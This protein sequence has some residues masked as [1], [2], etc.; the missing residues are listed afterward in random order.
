MGKFNISTVKSGEIADVAKIAHADL[1]I[2]QEGTEEVV[3]SPQGSAIDQLLNAPIDAETAQAVQ[4]GTIAGIEAEQALTEQREREAVPDIISRRDDKGRVD[5]YDYKGLE[6]EKAVDSAN[7]GVS[8]DGGLSARARNMSALITGKELGLGGLTAAAQNPIKQT[9]DS[10]KVLNTD[11]VLDKGFLQMSSVITENAI[12]NLAYGEGLEGAVPDF[13]TGVQEDLVKPKGKNLQPIP[14]A[15]GN[16]NIG[17]EINRE[18]QRYKNAQEGIPTDQYTDI[19]DEQATLLGD[20][21][22][23]LYYEANKND[24]GKEFMKR[25]KT[26][27]GQTAF[28]L[29][30]HGADRLK[31]GERKRKE[32]FP[33]Q[34]VRPTKTPTPGG[35]LVGEGRVYTKRVSSKVR[36]PI[37]G[38]EVLNAAMR[39][40]NKIPN[41]VDK[42]RL[43]ILFATAIPVL[44]GQV[45]PDHVFASMN[46]VGQDKY[47]DFVAKQNK[48]ADFDADQNYNDLINDLAQDIFGIS[49]ERK[50]ANYL[51]YY[52]QA[53]NGR[54]APQQTHFDPTRSKTVR[55]VTRNAVPSKATPGSRVER[56]LRQMYAM[57]LVKGADAALPNERDRLLERSTPQL[58]KWGKRL[59][60]MV[61]GITDDQ[62]EA[63]AAA[64]EQGIP[65]T[66]P[67]FPQLPQVG[68]DPNSDA[69]L[70]AVIKSKGEDGQAFI[71]GVID[72]TNYYENKLNNR[73]HNS[74]FNAYM[75]GK[76]NGLATNGMQMGSV[77]V[78]FK[79]GVL[80]SQG[81]RL[82][83]NDEDIRDSLRNVL[84]DLVDQGFEGDTAQFNGEINNIA[85]KLYSDR[86]LNKSTTMTFGYGMELDSFKK[87]LNNRLDELAENDPDLKQSLHVATNQGNPETRQAL[88][89]ALYTKYVQGLQGALDP[90]ALASRSLMRSAA[91]I[92][93]LTN[94]LFTLE[95]PT[96]FELNLG[97][98]ETTG[99]ES[100]ERYK[101]W[102]GEKYEE[103]TAGQFGEEVTAA[104]AKRRTDA[105]GKLTLEP[106][107]IAY[108]GSVPG[109]VQ[110]VDAATVALTASG[111]SWSKLVGASHGNPYL[112]T[113]YDAFKVDA[114]GYDVVLNETNQNWKDVNF[115]WSYLEETRN[116]M[117]SLREKWAE[118]NK[119]RSNTDPLSENEWKMAGY[120]LAPNK[121][122]S[123]KVYPTNLLNKF[124]KLME[125]TGDD[126]QDSEIAFKSISNIIKDM[127]AAGYN[128]YQPPAQPTLIH[129]KTFINS[130]SHELNFRTR[131]NSM[132]SNTNL[133]KDNLKKKIN[134]EGHRV[135]QYY[136]H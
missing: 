6:A 17:H 90:D 130:L 102:T 3:E 56:N 74:Y 95:S 41:V 64:I 29:T 85:T 45:G 124:K 12:A 32:M 34:H 51:T 10:M 7:S 83:D 89:D 11:G 44:S 86:N 122:K 31:L 96:G 18:W 13:D 77:D 43:K 27:D 24:A 48:D 70:I 73:P 92:H 91:V 94:E 50:G 129:L 28:A 118:K 39:N 114:M 63:A 65:V 4:E 68:L 46:H 120:L 82:L 104:A 61:D 106:G 93:A 128:V 101:V 79:T 30:K 88:N 75:D 76:T 66:D 57:M 84:L 20:I 69:E 98:T 109:P 54:I 71:D 60:Q 103:R 58:V 111:K 78:A 99:W 40:M 1:P 119:N 117:D 52:M 33:K 62:V 35:Q 134:S 81:K 21:A 113:I 126:T 123:G 55:F 38:G 36:K 105:E 136:S 67:N 25:Y 49:R 115:K 47:N 14:K 19:S 125:S 127:K 26:D 108:G 80:R 116:A 5:V 131:L 2:Q 133:K 22:K 135:Y 8:E 9:F 121:T 107:G 37:A 42:Q 110:S 59:K 53:F 16:K 23:E 97:G 132:I 100:G 72:F 15:L 87:V 112:H